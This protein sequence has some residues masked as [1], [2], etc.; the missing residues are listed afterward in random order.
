MFANPL[1]KI[2][3]MLNWHCSFAVVMVSLLNST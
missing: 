3:M 1:S 2:L